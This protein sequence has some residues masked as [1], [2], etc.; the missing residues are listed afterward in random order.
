MT[1]AAA[2]TAER[3]LRIC[4]FALQ[5]LAFLVLA[6]LAIANMALTL[7]TMEPGFCEHKLLSMSSEDWRRNYNVEC[8]CTDD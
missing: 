2:T 6:G 4:A 5:F 8:Q 3:A 1:A 7:L